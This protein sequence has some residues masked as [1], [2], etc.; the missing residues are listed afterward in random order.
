M[1]RLSPFATL[2]R[3]GSDRRESTGTE[4][5]QSIVESWVRTTSPL[6]SSI[7]RAWP[8]NRIIYDSEK[9][10]PFLAYSIVHISNNSILG[11]KK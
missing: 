6:V 7:A 4:E 11:L 3:H 9:H 2:S 10:I 1:V 8:N 5:S